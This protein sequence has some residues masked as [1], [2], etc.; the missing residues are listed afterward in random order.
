MRLSLPIVRRNGATRKFRGLGRSTLFSQQE[1][2]AIF[3]AE[4]DQAV[5]TPVNLLTSEDRQVLLLAKNLALN[6]NTLFAQP[7]FPGCQLIW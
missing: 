4:S 2:L 7:L 5:R 6:L 1:N 3:N